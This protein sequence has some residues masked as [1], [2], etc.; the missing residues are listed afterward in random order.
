M[1]CSHC[2]LILSDP[3]FLSDS[4][5]EVTGTCP[6]CGYA[7]HGGSRSDGA[8][9]ARTA[10]QFLTSLVDDIKSLLFQPHSFFRR[11]PRNAGL[12][13]PL[14]FALITHWLGRS[15]GY[16]WSTVTARTSE[17]MVSHWMNL[18][19]QLGGHND[20]IDALSRSAPW[21]SM[22]HQF[23]DWFWGMGSVITDPFTT[24]IGMLITSFFVFL[25]AR[26]FV[27]TMSDAPAS[28]AFA[29]DAQTRH[30]VTYESAVRIMAYGAVASIFMSLPI[31]GS[32]IAVIYGL[33]ISVVGAKEVY[34]VGTGRALVVVLFP[35]LLVFGI[36]ASIIGLML[37]IAIKLFAF[38]GF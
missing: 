35:K 30:V 20:Q 4:L 5:N 23:F 31:A 6:N 11:M 25:G 34:Q 37:L 28:A 38:G 1:N 21:L 19:G 33:Y 27:G 12:I 22:K 7:V 16:L 26:L 36:I 8:S 29:S 9:H 14:A 24:L 10:S 17:Q 18:L 13:Q 2:G 3:A 15:L 32:F